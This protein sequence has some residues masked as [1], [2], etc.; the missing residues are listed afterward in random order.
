L[1]AGFEDPHL[2]VLSPRGGRIELRD[3][4]L[5]C[6]DALELISLYERGE[7]RYLKPWSC[8]DTPIGNGRQRIVCRD[9]K[10]SFAIQG[11]EPPD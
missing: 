9:G 1:V 10:K 3:S 8:T 5:G 6:E 11:Y 4:G 2:C 7:Y